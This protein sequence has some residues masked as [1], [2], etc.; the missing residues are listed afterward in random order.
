MRSLLITSLSVLMLAA[1]PIAC[2][3]D[4]GDSSASGG[5]SGSGGSTGGSGGAAGSSS[6]GTGGTAGSSSGGSAGASTGGSSGSAGASSGGSAGASADA[7]TNGVSN[8]CKTCATA[9]CALQ[10]TACLANAECS[11]CG[12]VDWE[13]PACKDNAQWEDLCDCATSGGNAPCDTECGSFCV[14]VN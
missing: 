14:G 4:D 10:L 8:E 6:G 7:G 13:A 3:S 5:K 2:G 1:S 12:N 11:S 9:A